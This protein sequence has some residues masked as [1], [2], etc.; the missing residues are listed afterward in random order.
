MSDTPK[1]LPFAPPAKQTV[2]EATPYVE[3]AVAS[4]FSFL[5]GA[6]HSEELMLQ[7]AHLQLTGLGLCDRN[8]VAGVVRAYLVRREQNITLKYH[9]GARLVFDDGTPDILAY[10]RDRAAWGRLCRLLTQGNLR[11]EKGDCLL[12]LDDL[13]QWIEGLELIVMPESTRETPAQRLH[14]SRTFFGEEPRLGKEET[15]AAPEHECRPRE[16]GDPVL[17]VLSIER[18]GVLDARWS[19]RPG[20]PKARPGCGHDKRNASTLQRLCEAAPGRVRLAACMLYRGNDRARIAARA[21]LA[22]ELGVPLIAVNDVLYHHPERR[23]LQDVLT[24]IREHLT[25]DKAGRKL[26]ANAERYL[27]PGSEMARL[28]EDYP[29]AIAETVRLSDTLTFTLDELKSEYPEENRAGFATPQEALK[30]FTWEGAKARY[31]KGIPEKTRERIAH[32]F[33][34][35]AR[36]DYAPYFL[37][38]HHIVKYARSL[39][40]LCQGRGSAANSAV[41]FCLGITE[42]DPSQYQLLFERFISDNRGEPPDIDVDFEH[43]RR[44]EVIQHIYD[45]YGRDKTGIAAT[46]ISYRGRSAIR[47]V[48]KAFGLSEDMIGALASSIWGMGGGNVRQSDLLRTGLDPKSSRV[49]HVIDCVNAIQGFP[50]H[51]SQ[52]VGGFVITRS[53]LDEVVPIMNGAMDK[54]THVEWD[55]DDLDA[56]NLLKVDVLGLGMLTCIR[57]AFEL[58]EKHYPDALPANSFARSQELATLASPPPERGRSDCEAIRVGVVGE[59]NEEVPPPPPPP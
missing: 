30:H 51:L 4:N 16:S 32:E 38:V 36:R 43:E 13:I 37:T 52:H 46:V 18:Q 27:K 12:H 41:C 3:F 39:G 49:K 31:P 19:L 15:I 17:R 22:A 26:A 24:C 25:I 21:K 34:L 45:H 35:I 5:R 1:I 55:K 56:L 53:R 11:A 14:K 47:E 59:R 8:S 50:R 48:G 57:K 7:A 28:F 9:A 20:W 54:R 44:E 23:P 58:L 29:D 2:V 10:P 40:I 42:V 6:S 33:G